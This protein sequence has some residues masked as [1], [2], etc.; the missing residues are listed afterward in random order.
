MTGKTICVLGGSGFVGRRAVDLLCAQGFQV[1]VLTRSRQ[2][3]KQLL[4]LP[5]VEVI[6][7]DV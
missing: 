1:R 7:A 2:R 6:Q 3:A 4:V 5:T